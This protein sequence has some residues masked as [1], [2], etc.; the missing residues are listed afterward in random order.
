MTTR[1]AVCQP[2]FA[3]ARVAVHRPD[4]GLAKLFPSPSPCKQ[5][6]CTRAPLAH[7]VKSA[8]PIVPSIIQSHP[9]TIQAS[10]KDAKKLTRPEFLRQYSNKTALPNWQTAGQHYSQYVGD[11]QLEWLD[12]AKALGCD[13]PKK[14]G[15]GRGGHDDEQGHAQTYFRYYI[16]YVVQEK[17]KEDYNTGKK[18]EL[19]HHLNVA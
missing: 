8:S 12:I 14:V 4:T 9:G 13:L 3:P 1:P 6:T 18:R 15:H 19:K 17:G 10:K 7:E 2:S 5:L 16:E 11:D